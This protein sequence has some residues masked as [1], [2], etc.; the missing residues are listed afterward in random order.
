MGHGFV[1]ADFRACLNASFLAKGARCESN[2]T[3][4]KCPAA[5]S[6]K[7][8]CVLRSPYKNSAAHRAFVQE[9]DCPSFRNGDFIRAVIFFTH[10]LESRSIYKKGVITYF[11]LS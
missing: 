7:I 1:F 9:K 11:S 8:G 10:H 2:G 6:M 3:L 5:H 4:S